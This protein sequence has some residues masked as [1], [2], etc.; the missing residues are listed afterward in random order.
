MRRHRRLWA[1]LAGAA[2]L[3]GGN[4]ALRSAPAAPVF[5]PVDVERATGSPQLKTWTFNVAAPDPAGYV[6]CLEN[7]G[8]A[9]QYARVS[10]AQISLNNASIFS[11]SDFNQNV[12]TLSRAVTLGASNRLSLEL[13]SKPGSGLTLTLWRGRTCDGG[14]QEPVNRPPV[15]TSTPVTSATLLEPFTYPAAATDPDGDAVSLSF[16]SGPLAMTFAPSTGVVSWLPPGTGAFNVVLRATDS[17]SATAT[18]TFTVVVARAAN[19]PPHLTPIGNRR[20]PAGVP[21]RLELSA[22]DP[23]PGDLLMFSLDSGPAGASVAGGVRW[24]PGLSDLGTH[25]FAV[26]VRDAAGA[27][28]TGS[29]TVEVVASDGAPV[30]DPIEDGATTTGALF[31]RTITAS[32]PNP[33]DALTFSRVSGPSGLAVTPAGQLSWTP[34]AAQLGDHRV[35]VMVTDASGL[36]D[37]AS[38]NVSVGVPPLPQAPVARDDR[39]AVR[40]GATLGVPPPGVLANDDDPNGLPLSAQLVTTT[41]RGALSLGVDGAFTYTPNPSLPA[42]TQPALAFTHSLPAFSVTNSQPLVVDLDGDGRPEIVYLAQGAFATRRLVAVHGKDGSTAW[43]I[44]AYDSAGSPKIELCAAFC[45]LAAG[46]LDGDGRPEILAVHSDS[47]DAN[48][49]RR[50]IMAFNADGTTRWT[51]DDIVDGTNVLST[52]GLFDMAVADL[53]GDGAPEIVT[54]H[55]GKA[56]ATPAGVISEDLVTVFNGAGHIK[57]TVRVPG[58]AS[59][60]HLVVSDID[61]DGSPDILIGGATLNAN[62]T[63][64]WNVKNSTPT[65]I[66][67][68]AVGNLDDDPFAEIVYTDNFQGLSRYE[69]NG[70]KTWG[71]VKQP[72]LSDYSIPTIGD[73]DGDGRAEIIRGV[74]GVE[75]WSPAGVFLRNMALP[76]GLLGYG[77]NPTIFDL[78]GDGRP[79]VI[80]QAARSQ[81]DTISA[82]GGLYIFD[83][84][85]GT[86]L[87][88]MAASRHAGDPG[89]S[90]GPIVADVDGDGSAEIVTGGWDDPV[91]LRVFKAASGV[92]ARTRPVWNQLSYH[93][94]NVLPNGGIPAHEAINWLTPGMN[95]FRV[96]APLPDERVEELDQFTYT[97][98]NGQL[99]SNE[100]TVRI[101]ILPPNTAPRILSTAPPSAS[102]TIEYLYAVR[103]VDPDAG[104]QITFSLPVGPAG[105]IVDPGTGL[106][107]WTPPLGA[108]G[109]V[110]A[111]VKATDSQGQSSSQS[112][113]IA[114]AAAVS[115]PSVVGSPLAA[116]PQALT[117]GGVTVGVVTMAPSAVTPLNSVMSQE[118]DAGTLVAG[119]TAINLVVSSGPAPVA[120]PY[121]LGKTESEAV[122]RLTNLGFAGVVT[123]AFSNGT[124]AGRV[125]AQAPAAG[126]PLVPG[127]VALQVS[128]GS[129]LRLRLQR[130]L[131]SAD[132]TI[133]FSAVAYDV[134]FNES[135][136]PALTYA[137]TATTLLSFGAL[138]AVVA[139]TIVPAVDTR[140]AFRLTATDPATGHSTSADFAVT[141]PHIPGLRSMNDVLGGMSEALADMQGLAYQGRL[142]LAVGDAAGMRSVLDQV[143]RR[144]R[145][146]DVNLLKLST[147]FTLPQ[148]FFPAPSDLPSLGLSATPNDLLAQEI[149]A[150]AKADL[151]A[152]TDGLREASTS[153]L[154][155]NAL[156]DQFNTRAARMTGVS[157]SEWGVIKAA[158]VMTVL[159]SQTYPA[160]FTAF[161]D[162]LGHI[163][164]NSAPPGGGPS[165]RMS[166]LAEETV[167]MGLNMLIDKIMEES[168]PLLKMRSDALGQASWAASAVIAA[169]HFRDKVQGQPLTAV[170]AGGSLQFHVFKMFDS[171]VEADLDPDHPLNSVLVTIGPDQVDAPDFHEETAAIDAADTSMK[172]GEAMMKVYDFIKN[173]KANGVAEA[174]GGAFQGAGVGYRGCLFSSSPGCSQLVFPFGFKSVYTYDPPAGMN[175]FSG[176][177]VP[178]IFLL[179]DKTHGVVY[180]DTP[181]FLPYQ[182]PPAIP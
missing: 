48:G 42:G 33:G 168:N 161:T 72:S 46:D 122:A 78:N 165:M 22:D 51:S 140:G 28:D 8:H 3:F 118:P 105:M 117:D 56:P 77:G 87:H 99:S 147:P 23:D 125:F 153:T 64:K 58:R 148:G 102:P 61:V 172:L 131:T 178:I 59:G 116:A 134:D 71:G 1:A 12:A 66:R 137:V 111:V 10:S 55:Q 11:P 146:V 156:A 35:T 49:L 182:P 129:G 69:H 101:D 89:E 30:L 41:A 169:H 53:D 97:A 107:R 74:D 104:E 126:T 43:A 92:W 40:R 85:T 177:P 143:V 108:G 163:V 174:V 91:R 135:P 170:V 96:N 110:M 7:G 83:G 159:L 120:V 15:F 145:Q 47:E 155:L 123:R 150:D 132:S 63:I 13:R 82:K 103:A 75:V 95:N 162:E 18:Q 93:V 67:D 121:V 119:G 29:F 115:V 138:P 65:S 142:A 139:N 98:H 114:L 144:W 173:G 31:L 38:F 9:G 26:R 100:A 158:P 109:T 73:V 81:F 179:F 106:V 128:A 164:E 4:A 21:F 27:A 124:P 54:V 152:W 24:T 112:F 79:E 36:A 127:N 37:V 151:E 20:I 166:L 90:E 181:V 88:S 32:D 68:V 160:F 154:T 62:G 171:F 86:L 70:T 130:N 80:Y 157:M 5:G 52:T 14:G 167:V 45:E 39:F 60:R 57:W 84:P 176:I 113:S 175:D 16:V 2:L 19:R 141:F 50:K 180:V 76:N 136:A 44:N 133:P 34:G 149:L 94:T 17:K 6:L 25:T